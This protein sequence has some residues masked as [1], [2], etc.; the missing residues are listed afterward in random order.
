MSHILFVQPIFAP[1]E[2]RALANINSLMSFG[3]YLK[4]QHLRNI[5]VSFSLGGWAANDQLWL[6]VVNTI[7]NYIAPNVEPVRFDRNF[8]KAVVVNN[9]V[10]RVL[11]GGGSVIDAILTADSDIVFLPTIDAFFERLVVAALE[12]EKNRSIKW[13]LVAPNMVGDC[14]HFPSCYECGFYYSVRVDEKE[15]KERLVWPGVP[16]GIAGGCLYINRQLW[17]AVGGYRVLGVYASDDAYLLVDCHQKGFTYQVL[18]TLIVEH[19]VETDVEYGRWRLHLLHSHHNSLVGQL[20][21]D[22]LEQR[23]REVDKFWTSRKK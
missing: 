20:V 13:G 21:G 6:R 9:L 5:Q 4:R 22:E 19:P 2:R 12:S 7:K 15:F 8:G 14:R 17:E 3:N 11:S 1:D 10:Q 18:A 23:V 16:S